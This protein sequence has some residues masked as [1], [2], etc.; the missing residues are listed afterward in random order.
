M[1]NKQLATVVDGGALGIPN[2][3]CRQETVEFEEVAVYQCGVSR[4]VVTLHAWV[5]VV[6]KTVNGKNRD[7]A[8]HC[9][10]LHDL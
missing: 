10:S 5:A 7:I 1:F 4:E 6:I 2:F 8:L 9:D 3:C